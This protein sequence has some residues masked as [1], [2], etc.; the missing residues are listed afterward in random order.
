MKGKSQLEE[1]EKIYIYTHTQTNINHKW[2]KNK[3][4]ENL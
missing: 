2:M 1:G 3:R 4:E